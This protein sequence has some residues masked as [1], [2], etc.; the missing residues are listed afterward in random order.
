MANTWISNQ[1]KMEREFYVEYQPKKNWMVKLKSACRSVSSNLWATINEFE[2]SRKIFSVSCKM[3]LAIS[4][5]SIH[6]WVP[7]SDENVGK[8]WEEKKKP[9]YTVL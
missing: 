3:C 9:S 4:E 6:Q 5:T 1:T 7:D 8:C 2:I